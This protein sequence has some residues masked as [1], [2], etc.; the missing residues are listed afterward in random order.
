MSKTIDFGIDLGTTNSCIARWEGGS[1]R[2][3]QNND[4]MN[5]T[6]SA[7]HVLR[8]GRVI[9]GRRAYSALMTDPQNVAVEFKRWM[10]QS[11]RK[12]FPAAQR[13]HSAEKLSAEILKSLRE[14]VRRKA[15]LDVTDAVI[16]VPA[17][18]GALQCEAT[19]RAAQLAGFNEAPLLQEPIAAAI[20]YGVNPGSANQRWLVFDLGGGTLDIAVISTRDGRLTVLEH[21][22]NNLLG[23]K[24]IDNLVVERILLPA[25]ESVFELRVS[26]TGGVRAALLPKL[27]AK[28]EEV[29]ID[30]S[31]DTRVV[32]S[33]LDIGEDDAGRLIELDVPFSRAQLESLIEPLIDKCCVLAEEA[34][35]AARLSPSELDRVLLVGG[36]TQS[37]LVRSIVSDRLRAPID[38]SVDPMTILARGAAVYASSLERVKGPTFAASRDEKSLQIKLAYEPVTADL[39]CP[40]A[41]RLMNANAGVEVKVEAEDG[42]WTSGWMKLKNDFFEVSAPLKERDT[43]TFWL[44]A[45]DDRG[46]L[47]EIDTTEFKIR[48]G[49]VISAP[50]L[51]HTLSL[52]I[53]K[54]GEKRVLDPVFAKGTL[55]PAQKTIRYRT[56]RAVIPNDPT[57][58][59]AIKLWE[60]EY[61]DDP[62]ANEWVGHALISNK[63]VQRRI[64]AG[65]E[66]ELN[67]QRSESALITIEAFVPHL[68][69]SFSEH[70]YSPQ[71]EE[72][73]F[74]KLSTSVASEARGYRERLSALEH[75]MA[76]SSNGQVTQADLEALKRDIDELET[77]APRRP[78]DV[79][80]LNPDDARRL[81]HESKSVRGKLSRLEC[82]NPESSAAAARTRFVETFEVTTDVVEKFGTNLK[83]QQLAIYRKELERAAAK[84]DD[85]IINRLCEEVAAL[86]WRVLFKHDWFWKQVFDSLCE[87]DEVFIARDEAQRLQGIGQDAIS[88]GN[89]ERLREVVRALWKL[90][91]KNDA[92]LSRG[93]ALSS[94][95]RQ[96]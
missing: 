5:V 72:Q 68:N 17:A 32:V 81:V 79:D 27:R 56:T 13:E 53:L 51:P 52:E 74:S 29:K 44:Y 47:L 63:D 50:P 34:L 84:G 2:I 21:R 40:V 4:Q 33:L 14:D 6:P 43:T 61:L 48:H 76:E 59:I 11:D 19:A 93:R 18:F 36:P 49:L 75:S 73:D 88:E 96:F 28:A 8:T 58:D 83:S 46:K 89:G 7:V 25:L 24:D 35:A 94:G 91:P 31:T 42:M 77:K 38:L 62:D 90:Q 70:V 65:S 15:G 60:G 55:L 86:R 45:R 3:F 87:P 30:L 71:R 16:T 41:G 1:D 39:Q 67:I 64:P 20:G 95:L 22:G 80:T 26:G 54:A 82:E 10:G 57:S 37:P 66:I 9:V 12:Q 85:K 78:G 23:G 92:D 69:K